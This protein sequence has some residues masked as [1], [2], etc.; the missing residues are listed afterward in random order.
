MLTAA[1]IRDKSIPEI[2]ATLVEVRRELF[3][4]LNAAER[5]K[6]MEKPHLMREKR[7]TIARLHT[8]LRQKQE[9]HE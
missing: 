1:E 5:A 4:L 2:E 6:R 3:A 9:A 7:K 8:I